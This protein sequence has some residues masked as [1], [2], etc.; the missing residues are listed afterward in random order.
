MATNREVQMGFDVLDAVPRFRRV[1]ANVKL[2]S[3]AIHAENK[4]ITPEVLGQIFNRIK[5]QL[6]VNG[7]YAEAYRVFFER[8][9]EYALECNMMIL[10]GVFFRNGATVTTDNLEELLLPGNP[11]NV[12]D[13]LCLTAEARQAQAEEAERQSIISNLVGGLKPVVD[14]RGRKVLTNRSGFRV[15][16]AAE[17]ERIKALPLEGLRQLRDEKAEKKRLQQMSPAELRQAVRTNQ[18][19]S[20]R[21]EQLSDDGG[22]V[23]Y[24]KHDGNNSS[25]NLEPILAGDPVEL[26]ALNIKRLHRDDLHDVIRRFGADAVNAVL[27]KGRN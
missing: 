21:Y 24:P 12:L 25:R 1:E 20:S 7:E 15:L 27:A 9:P 8:H 14:E 19:S 3:D 18:P 6:A 16:Y 10:D 4:K 2:M 22:A 17:V 26:T 23:Y 13:Q 11:H 5:P